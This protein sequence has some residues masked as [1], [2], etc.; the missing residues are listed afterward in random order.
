MKRLSSAV[1]GVLCALMLLGCAS[2]PPERVAVVNPKVVPLPFDVVWP[3]LVDHLASEHILIKTVS[4]DD[5]FIDTAFQALPEDEVREY[6]QTFSPASMITRGRA[7]ANIYV[8]KVSE[9]SVEVTVVPRLQVYEDR[10]S[11]YFRGG[12]R[13][14]DSTGKLEAKILDI[15]RLI[16]EAGPRADRPAGG[17]DRDSSK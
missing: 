5:G 14:V 4:R 8:R 1:L 17:Q 3:Q 13:E 7:K 12:W 10:V 9:S 11:R 16:A 6:A 15:V 2:A